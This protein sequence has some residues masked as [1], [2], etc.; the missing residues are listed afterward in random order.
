MNSSPQTPVVSRKLFPTPWKIFW[1]ALIVRLL[2]MTL[3]RTY[4]VR[5]IDQHFGFAWE[6]GRIARALAT[7]YGYADPFNGHTGPTAWLPPLYTLLIAGVFKIFGV[8]TA[9]SAWVLLAL[10]CL[11]SAFIALAVY[12]IACRCYGARVALWSGWIWALYP[13]AMQYAVRW[14]WEMTLTTMLFAWIL[15]LALRMRGVGDGPSSQQNQ[16]TWPRWLFFGLLWGLLALSN[17]T[18]LIF[19]PVCALW[20]FFGAPDKKRLF[21]KAACAALVFCA[22]LAPW[23]VRNQF[24][25]HHFIPLRGNFGAEF[26][27][28]NGPGSSGLLMA[29]DHPFMDK[30]Q[31]QLYAELGEVKYAAYR[32]HLGMDYVRAHP[33]H[34]AGICLL[35]FYY[36]WISVVHPFDD[37]V[38]VEFVRVLN[39]SF[40][41][42]AGLLGLA[43]SLKRRIPASKLFLGAFILM[44]LPYYIVVVHARFRHPLEPLIC[45]LGVY[46]FQ[47]AEPGWVGNW[48][49]GSWLARKLRRLTPLFRLG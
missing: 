22:C 44:P 43:L 32:G 42:V 9:Q 46:L 26:Y 35:R 31:L 7:G 49:R 39:F 17:S 29:Y 25:F 38:L 19:L 1:T 37:S 23:M 11:M 5:P 10:N 8:Y 45:V 21:G 6:A 48:L 30:E 16:Q 40:A 20:I 12:E 36:F 3:A 13:A 15:V 33:R 18:P 14:I 24:A 41:S 27:L 2:Y 28:G 4:R 47:S 34:Y